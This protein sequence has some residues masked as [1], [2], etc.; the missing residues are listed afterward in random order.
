MNMQIANDTYPHAS[1]DGSFE[2][3]ET[4]PLATMTA[5]FG[6]AFGG[7]ALDLD[8][9]VVFVHGVL[10]GVKLATSVASLPGVPAQVTLPIACGQIVRLSR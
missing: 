2:Y 4:V 9:R 5:A 3:H 1:A 7:A 6:K 10:P 8:H